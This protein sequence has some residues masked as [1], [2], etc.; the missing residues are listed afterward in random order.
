M[1]GKDIGMLRSPE[2]NKS[3]STGHGDAAGWFGTDGGTFCNLGVSNWER[4]VSV[5]AD[6]D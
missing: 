3:R 1:R 5:G 4:R 6:F 2:I